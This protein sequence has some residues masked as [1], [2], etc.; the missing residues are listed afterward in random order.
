MLKANT[1]QT[2]HA[3]VCTYLQGNLDSEAAGCHVP[4]DA[5]PGSL[6]FVTD[7]QQLALAR[8]RHAAILVVQR[9]IAGQLVP[10][11]AA[12]GCCF[13]VSSVPMGMAVLLQH[14]DRKRERFTQWGE[15]HPTAVVHPAATLGAD[16]FLGPYCVIGADTSIGDG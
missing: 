7:A 3:D 16:V 15:R 8:Q 11:E 14:F 4:A 6:V 1:V 9:D 5:G 2:R 10:N 12:F 13:S